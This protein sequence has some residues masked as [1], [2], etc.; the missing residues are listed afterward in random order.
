VL[1]QE[2]QAKNQGRLEFVIQDKL[3]NG[4]KRSDAVVIAP[5]TQKQTKKE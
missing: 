3:F 2:A 4:I 5:E 1:K